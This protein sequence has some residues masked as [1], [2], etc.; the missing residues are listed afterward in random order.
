MHILQLNSFFSQ[1]NLQFLVVKVV[2]KLFS[3]QTF[4]KA[5]M[6]LKKSQEAR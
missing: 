2:N 1:E 3:Q 5:S 4:L 6:L